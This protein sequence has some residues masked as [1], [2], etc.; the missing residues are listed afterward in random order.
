MEPIHPV[1]EPM[2]KWERRIIIALAVAGILGWMR[3]WQEAPNIVPA[4]NRICEWIC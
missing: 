4:I 1:I 2:T 3:I